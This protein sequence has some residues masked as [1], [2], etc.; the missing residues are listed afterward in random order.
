MEILESSYVKDVEIRKSVGFYVKCV[1]KQKKKMGI[2]STHVQ[3]AKWLRK[4]LPHI[5]PPERCTTY[6]DTYDQRPYLKHS[7]CNHRIEITASLLDEMATLYT[8]CHMTSNSL[9]LSGVIL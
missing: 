7:K 1:K 4:N 5:D 8:T 2:Y 3:I 6:I 9:D